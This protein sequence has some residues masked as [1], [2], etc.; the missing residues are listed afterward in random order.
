MEHYDD[1]THIMDTLKTIESLALSAE[2]FVNSIKNKLEPNSNITELMK[3]FFKTIGVEIYTIE[4][5]LSCLTM[6]LIK[7]GCV[8][9][10]LLI[11]PNVYLRGFLN[12]Q[13]SPITL[14]KLLIEIHTHIKIDSLPLE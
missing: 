14:T 1:V 6:Y 10:G 8:K 13:E 7:E 2:P 5:F 4:N 12:L 11:V 3:D 9:E